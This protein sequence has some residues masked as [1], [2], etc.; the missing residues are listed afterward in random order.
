MGGVF[1]N[2]SVDRK[3]DVNNHM[4][5][6]LK[7]VCGVTTTCRNSQVI[8]N[9]QDNAAGCDLY[10]YARQDNTGDCIA[11]CTSNMDASIANAMYDQFQPDLSAA[12]FQKLNIKTKEDYTNY[13]KQELNN[14]CNGATDQ[15]NV[16]LITDIYCN[17]QGGHL[18]IDSAQTNRGSARTTCLL[19]TGA[20]IANTLHE[21]DATTSRNDPFGFGQFFSGL[22]SL[23]TVIIIIVVVLAILAGTLFFLRGRSSSSA[24]DPTLL[25]AIVA[26]RRPSP[27]QAPQQFSR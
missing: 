24:I 12:P 6:V 9:I 15:S 26:S 3:I 11:E 27:M 21:K 8:R 18:V 19:Q 20:N 4:E 17:A 14:S 13:V 1:S 25:A 5:S 10:I 2:E 16:N 23:G 22:G 7:N